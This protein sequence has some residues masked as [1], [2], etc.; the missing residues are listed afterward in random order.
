[1]QTGFFSGDYIHASA[2]QQ[3]M[4]GTKILDTMTMNADD[5]SLQNEDYS[6]LTAFN[7]IQLGMVMDFDNA[8]EYTAVMIKTIAAEAGFKMY[9][10]VGVQNII[11]VD[12]RM[13]VGAPAITANVLGQKTYDLT[14]VPSLANWEQYVFVKTSAKTISV[15]YFLGAVFTTRKNNIWCDFTN[16]SPVLAEARAR[17]KSNA[18]TYDN[19]L[20][21]YGWTTI[22]DVVPLSFKVD[23]NTK[24]LLTDDQGGALSPS[25]EKYQGLPVYEMATKNGKLKFVVDVRK[26]CRKQTTTSTAIA[27]TPNTAAPSFISKSSKLKKIFANGKN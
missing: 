22:A 8:D 12:G 5:E 21:D 7:P 24:A 25:A 1:M 6:V 16:Q 10:P 23:L 4:Y 14:T 3:F 2:L 19:F 11:L 18:S 17:V 13:Y 20:K 27:A 9:L 26:I 15:D